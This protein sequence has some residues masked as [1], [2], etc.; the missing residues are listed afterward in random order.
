MVAHQ[1]V[2]HTNSTD[3]RRVTARQFASR[4]SGNKCTD[5]NLRSMYSPDGRFVVS[6]SEDG[7]L[8]AWLEETGELLLEGLAVGLRG[9][10]RDALAL[11]VCTPLTKFGSCPR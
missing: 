7:S 3:N 9:A 8:F 10:L 4:Y 6:G 1:R 5:Y 2:A 11:N